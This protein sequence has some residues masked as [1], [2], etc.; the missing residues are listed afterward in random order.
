M[1][2]FKQLL[3]RLDTLFEVRVVGISPTQVH[4]WILANGYV[5]DSAQHGDHPKYHHSI[6]KAPVSGVN[7]HSKDVPPGAISNIH[8][9]MRNHHAEHGFEY[10]E[11]DDK[12]V[13]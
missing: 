12:R 5:L 4:K 11:P 3:E 1:L 6:T 8:K 2:T 13:K 7:R 9:T 10:I